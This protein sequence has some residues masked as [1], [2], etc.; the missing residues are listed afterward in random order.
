MHAGRQRAASEEYRCWP[1]VI[2]PDMHLVATVTVDPE[3]QSNLWRFRDPL[4]R[5]HL[6]PV[7]EQKAEQVL[8]ALAPLEFAGAVILDPVQQLEVPR[9]LQR[10]SIEVQESGAADTVTVSPAGLIGEYNFGRAVGMMLKSA[11]WDAQGARAVIMGAGPQ[12]KAI[13]REL[14][15]MGISELTVLAQNRPEAEQS[16]P[17]LAKSTQVTARSAGD[18]LADRQLQDSDLIVRLDEQAVV[19]ALAL[20]PH[21]TLVD[22]AH[23]GVSAIRSQAL[24]VGALSF[25]RRDLD[26]HLIALS[27]SQVLGGQIEA[28]PFLTLFHEGIR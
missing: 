25:N 3:L 2:L 8:G 28:E 23:G 13:A 16:L 21:L 12:V 11:N 26:A 5:Y 18:P 9:L 6:H 4:G 27:L 17:L 22:L 24:N 1:L 15:S 20:G 14:S 19:P 10:S 7:L